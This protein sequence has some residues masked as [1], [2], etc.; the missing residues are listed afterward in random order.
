[1]IHTQHTDWDGLVAL[2]DGDDIIE[3]CKL[4]DYSTKTNEG[5][6]G[7]EER[8][9]NMLDRWASTGAPIA[10]SSRSHYPLE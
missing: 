10:H 6:V 4:R 1:M 2:V 9:K 5:A 8:K 3:R 7:E